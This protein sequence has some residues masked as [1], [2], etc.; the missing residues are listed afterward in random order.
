MDAASHQGRDQET[1]SASS[2]EV[3]DTGTDIQ[4]EAWTDTEPPAKATFNLLN[5]DRSA[6]RR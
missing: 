5:C 6:G 1:L 3:T 2:V 4:G